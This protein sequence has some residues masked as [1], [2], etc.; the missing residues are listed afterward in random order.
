MGRAKLLDTSLASVARAVKLLN[1]GVIYC[2]ED[3]CVVYNTC[4]LSYYLLYRSG[5]L[6]LALSHLD[7]NINSGGSQE[8]SQIC[9]PRCSTPSC[10]RVTP[11]QAETPT[12]QSTSSPGKRTVPD[13]MAFAWPD[14]TNQVPA[15]LQPRTPQMRRRPSPTNSTAMQPTEA[16]PKRHIRPAHTHRARSAS[17]RRISPLHSPKRKPSEIPS[18]EG[19][20]A[21][22]QGAAAS[23]LAASA[24]RAA[25]EQGPPPSPPQPSPPLFRKGPAG[26]KAEDV[27]DSI[28]ATQLGS[29]SIT[30]PEAVADRNESQVVETAEEMAPAR[31]CSGEEGETT[32]GTIVSSITE[33]FE[34]LRQP[35]QDG[36]REVLI[37]NR[38]FRLL[39]L[40]GRGAFGVVW[41]AQELEGHGGHG[42]Q[43]CV[44]VKAMEATNHENFGAAVFEAEL[45][46]LLTMQLPLD[47]RDSVPKYVAHSACKTSTGGIVHIAMSFIPGFVLDQWMYAITDEEHKRVDVNQIVNGWLPGSRQRSMNLSGACSF[48]QDL[49]S[50]LSVVFAALAPIAFHRD[51]SSHNV[52][53]DI[54][55]EG[56]S[57]KP[58]FALIDFGLAVNSGSWS[59]DWNSS[60]LAGDPRY[61]SLAAWMALAFGFR[62][63]ET[64]PNPG[65]H[66]QYLFRIDHYSMGLL[67]LEVLFS[68]WDSDRRGDVESAPGILEARAAWCA[69]WDSVF[70]LFQMFHLQ[71]PQQTQQFLELSQQNVLRHMAD[72]LSEVYTTLRAAA[73]H[74]ANAERAQLLRVLADLVD[75][76][77]VFAWAE[78]PDILHAKPQMMEPGLIEQQCQQLQLDLRTERNSSPAKFQ[79]QRLPEVVRYNTNPGPHPAC[80]WDTSG[81]P[82]NLCTR[83][84]SLSPPTPISTCSMS[85]RRAQLFGQNFGMLIPQP[86]TPAGAAT[87]QINQT[88]QASELSGAA[89]GAPRVTGHTLSYV[90]PSPAPAQQPQP[91]RSPVYAQQVLASPTFFLPVHTRMSYATTH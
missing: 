76:N 73:A 67:G 23:V 28:E 53:V 51:I 59:H 15:L 85:H 91:P 63:V 71:G 10:V 5:C 21:L 9:T 52:L 61:W 24:A 13:M 3:F 22:D 69:F 50:Q 20:K 55:Q 54:V 81:S 56:D 78:I 45:L 18:P 8:K 27:V 29:Q 1:L 86:S 37:S 77:G 48:A 90:P 64:H 60:N 19:P 75:E 14:V 84:R 30:G 34:P 38:V 17:P 33:Q 12:K 6:E 66:R 65:F 62:Y 72:L 11:E 41:K 68:L 82:S 31:P 7:L 57:L 25:L 43:P 58:S 36:S 70:R 79:S 16:K 35:A 88:N 46:R 42:D 89:A 80:S 40:I 47:C 2:P 83:V 74:P 4:D 87:N 26:G 39:K 49:V 44:A 32:A